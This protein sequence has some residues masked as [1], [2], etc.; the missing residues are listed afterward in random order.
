MPEQIQSED[1]SN[2]ETNTLQNVTTPPAASGLQRFIQFPLTRIIIALLFVGG[3]LSV[4]VILQN[5]LVN[6]FEIGNLTLELPWVRILRAFAVVLIAHFA[7][8]AYVKIVEKRPV[9]E[10]SFDGFG[11]EL[12]TGIAWGLSLIH[13]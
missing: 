5:F 12:G 9:S 10:L 7:Y 11:K 4:G 8:T 1:T 13:I 3:A 6:I 2:T